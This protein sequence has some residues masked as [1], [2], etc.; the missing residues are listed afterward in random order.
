MR[1]I[2]FHTLYKREVSDIVAGD[3]KFD[4]DGVT[5][6]AG[7]HRYH[8]EYRYIRKIELVEQ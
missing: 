1:V 8:I 5:Y 6:S 2:Y 3:I 4:D 7:G